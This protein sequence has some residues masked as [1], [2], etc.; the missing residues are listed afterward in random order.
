[1]DARALT[2]P[3]N[4]ELI[5]SRALL[6]VN[7]QRKSRRI[8]CGRRGARVDE[9]SDGPAG[10]AR[11]SGL[12][13]TNLR[14]QAL[15]ALRNAVTSGEIEP[16]T[17]LVETELSSALSISR[18]TLRE[19]L[20]QLQQEGLVEA[21]ERG[22]LRVRTLSRAEIEDLFAVRSALEGLAAA[23]LARVA[24]RDAV[25]A[26]LRTALD[27]LDAATGSIADM[28]EIDLAFHRTLCELT[29]NRA[30][31][32]SWEGIAG[33]IRMSIMFAGADRA[34]AN[35][36]VSR[37]QLLVDAIAAGDPDRA[38][39]AVDEHMR[40]AAANLVDELA[41]VPAELAS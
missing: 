17:H 9:A 19:A 5:L 15:Q 21:A 16:G 36:S 41:H 35:M 7:G 8:L 32:H 33:S 24:E 6:T 37:H 12:T 18:G 28:V 20:R 27:A 4:G 30:L 34:V 31:V 25:V 2:Q 11:L 38:R 29:G 22:R 1:V 13:R 39:I 40:R 14:E 23:T 3:W 26:A 10:A